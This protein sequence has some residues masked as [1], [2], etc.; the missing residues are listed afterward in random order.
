MRGSSVKK[1]ADSHVRFWWS[2]LGQFGIPVSRQPLRCAGVSIPAL[3]RDY[4]ALQ[5][6]DGTY[7]E[8]QPEEEHHSNTGNNICMV[9]DDKLVAHHRRILVGL[10]S[11]PH[12]DAVWPQ[13]FFP[14]LFPSQMR[15][16]FF[17][18]LSLAF[19]VKTLK[20]P[21]CLF[22]WAKGQAAMNGVS[23]FCLW[24]G[25]ARPTN[26]TLHAQERNSCCCSLSPPRGSEELLVLKRPG[27]LHHI[28]IHLYG[29]LYIFVK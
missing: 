16:A 15:S 2:R 18:I 9:L 17:K 29:N 19:G 14:P 5:D 10:F 26:D 8:H 23:L 3:L 12:V 6:V 25:S 20:A 11:D 13:T 24:E 1:R 21:S 4:K 28:Y 27:L 7:L 22:L